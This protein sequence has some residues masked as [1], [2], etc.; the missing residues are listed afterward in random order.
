M[1]SIYNRVI[2]KPDEDPS[3][4][5]IGGFQIMLVTGVSDQINESIHNADNN[6]VFKHLTKRQVQS[7]IVVAAPEKLT[8]LPKEMEGGAG[9]SYWRQ[10]DVDIICQPGDRIWFHHNCIT[11]NEEARVDNEL[12]AV[13]YNLCYCIQRGDEL[14]CL[15][16]NMLVELNEETVLESGII[17]LNK[18]SDNMANKAQFFEGTIRYLGKPTKRERNYA[19]PL[20]VG[21]IVI[22][23][24]DSDIK[25]QVGDITYYRMK[26]PDILLRKVKAEV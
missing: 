20:E 9:Y 6:D 15:D 10:W 21:D 8:E 25:L 5:M 12:F 22:Y 19:D 1:R 17:L 14:I 2:V 13:P 3:T 16:D 7:G 4:V 18:Y 24:E 23:S 11:D 26:Y